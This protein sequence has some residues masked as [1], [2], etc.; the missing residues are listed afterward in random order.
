MLGNAG[1]AYASGGKRL[2]LRIV[3][4]WTDGMWRLY[5]LFEAHAP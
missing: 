1:P 3:G 2:E 4:N 5:A